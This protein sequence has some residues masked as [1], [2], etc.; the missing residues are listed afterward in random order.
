MKT[1][2]RL[3]YGEVFAA[4][5]FVLLAFLSLFFFFDFVEELAAIEGQLL[6][7]TYSTYRATSH[8]VHDREIGAFQ[9]MPKVAIA[10]L[11][12]LWF[13]FGVTS[14]I[15]ITAAIVFFPVLANTIVGLRSAPRDQIDLMTA[16]TASSRT[17]SR[18]PAFRL[19][20]SCPW[21]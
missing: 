16:F 11:F 10:P 15:I 17:S 21:Q 3:I 18:S 14:K 7:L 13:G 4:V 8:D 12:V 6:S 19:F 20:P 9:T 2:R 5:F 1:I